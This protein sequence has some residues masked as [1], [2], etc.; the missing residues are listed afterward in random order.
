MVVH[1]NPDAEEL[2]RLSNGKW[3]WIFQALANVP[4]E[5][6]DGNHHP[7]IL[8]GGHD[9]ARAVDIEVGALFCNQ[10]FREKNGDGIAALQWLLK[11]SFPEAL[12]LLADYHG[13]KIE[14]KGR[15]KQK[16]DPAKDL[17]FIEWIDA[18]AHIFCQNNPGICI[19]A[20]RL[21]GAVMAYYY[22]KG[23]VI[24]L[25]I[26]GDKLL[27]G[28]PVGWIVQDFNNTPLPT[29]N[30]A[31]QVV[32]QVKRKTT[33]GSSRGIVGDAAARALADPAIK[34]FYKLEGPP[35]YLTFL[36]CL[37][38]EPRSGVAAFTTAN[39]A[40]EDLRK[41]PWLISRL[42]NCELRII[43]DCDEPGQSG[44]EKIPAATA[45]S[46]VVKNYVLPYPIKKDHGED[47]RDW[48][49]SGVP[50][51]IATLEA[52]F[53]K[54]QASQVKPGTDTISNY[55]M[56]GDDERLPKSMADILRELQEKAGN[57]LGRV[58]SALFVDDPKHGLSWPIQPADLFG[59]LSS[60]VGQ[61]AWAGGVSFVKQT[62]LFS[63][64]RRTAS[65]YLSVE[66]LPHE[67]PLAD[68]YYRC[69]T[70]EPGNGDTLQRLLDRFC[71]SSAF[72]RELFKAAIVTPCWGGPAGARPAFQITSPFGRGMGKTSAVKNLGRIWGGTLS[73]AS[74]DDTNKMQT[75]LLSP[76]AMSKR[77]A[78]LDNVKSM[79]FS[80]ACWEAMLTA[81]SVGGHRLYVGEAMRPNTLT[82]FL[83]VNGSSLSTDIA[84]RVVTISLDRPNRSAT[85][86]EDTAKFIDQNRMALIAD[87]IGFLRSDRVY[88]LDKFTRWATWEKDI[89]RRLPAPNEMQRLILERQKT[90]D[91]E[92]D[93]AEI[94]EEYFG[95]QLDDL[96]YTP[97]TSR[98]LI[99]SAIAADWFG[100][101][102]NERTTT[103]AAGRKISQLIDEGRLPRL[104]KNTCHS[105]GRGL[106]WSGAGADVQDAVHRDIET[107]IAHRSSSTNF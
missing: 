101:A 18:F 10:C 69:G 40:G 67:P 22:G 31:G 21:A 62:E 66:E 102:T 87:C 78:I 54:T 61:V 7:C 84:Q 56:V 45:K 8:C 46:T 41:H 100:R 82:W 30:K 5:F 96:N 63:E 38:A 55:V 35:D 91:A 72:D 95:N 79:K 37:L 14:T 93:E 71:F 19:E 86:E 44:A 106:I 57:R 36:G 75:R 20:L 53:E 98:V 94:I 42:E 97:E 58:G 68:H 34:T 103:V 27:E 105:W 50:Q 17:Q 3:P 28:G 88:P 6:C 80:W 49:N 52:A 83:T 47:F 9:R 59:F 11:I 32:G 64:F 4:L 77:I 33:S 85:W 48:I 13:Y 74:G 81:E 51:P 90:A 76:D 43:H 29:F 89:L 25:P 70:I 2:K 26:Y 65:S 15:K 99:P 73:F 39:G 16:A 107:R 104:E 60:H 92:A 24:A 1:N 12:Q 23:P